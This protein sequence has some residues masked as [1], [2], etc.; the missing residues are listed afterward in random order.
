MDN[1][2]AENRKRRVTIQNYHGENLVG[3][4]HDSASTS[5]VIV[6]HGFQSSKVFGLR[7]FMQIKYSNS[8]TNGVLVELT[9]LAPIRRALGEPGFEFLWNYLHWEAENQR[10][11]S[12]S[13]SRA[14]DQSHSDCEILR[15][16][17][18]AQRA[19]QGSSEQKIYSNSSMR[20]M[21]PPI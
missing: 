11:K 17:H 4:L 9:Q 19:N 18:S 12:R 6:C 8:S 10:I 1:C 15:W 20:K 21:C 7:N 14:R 5:L 16:A 2:C 13:I 3:I